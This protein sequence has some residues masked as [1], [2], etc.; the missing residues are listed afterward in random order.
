MEPISLM[1]MATAGSGILQSA[2]SIFNNMQQ[3]R[4]ARDQ[5]YWQERMSNTAHQREVADLI[6]AGLNP[7]LSATGGRGASTPSSPLPTTSN[8]LSGLAEGIQSAAK[9]T[10]LDLPRVQAE[11]MLAK[12]NSARADAERRNIDADTM[13][14]LAF[15]S[16][17][18]QGAL[19]NKLL[20]DIANTQQATS[21]S[22]AQEI[23][24]RAGT[25]KTNQEVAV[26][27]AIVP[28]ITRGSNAIQQLVDWASSG[29][30][31]GDAAY[32]LVDKVKTVLQ[33]F[34][35]T[36]LP[37]AESIGR[38]IMMTIRKHA[39]S[40]LGTSSTGQGAWP[41]DN[42]SSQAP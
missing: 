29:G 27:K 15:G 20:A 16:P 19:Q 22:A 37:T 23:A 12:S 10:L 18:R 4:F 14:K 5:M 13:A 34:K 40:M 31:L 30:K 33:Q 3:I 38:Y 39:P 9:T 36:S 2:G 8:P 17:E 35:D 24:T 28:F 25:E 1:A 21:T 6:A 26:L 42:T 7:I 41:T 11:T 32:E